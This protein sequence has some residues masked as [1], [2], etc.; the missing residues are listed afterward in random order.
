[1]F[2]RLLRTEGGFVDSPADH[3]GATKYGLSLRFLV[4]QA[5]ISPS[6]VKMLDI[7]RDGEIDLPDIRDMTT[8]EAEAVY[9]RFF[10]EPAAAKLPP[11]FDAAVFDQTVND[12]L[13]PA[14]KLLQRTL[15]VAADKGWPLPVT[16]YLGP[17]TAARLVEDISL[18]GS[19]R[20]LDGYRAAAAGR[21]RQIVD[22]DPAQA[23]F[24]DGWLTRA[25][26]LGDV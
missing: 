11:P 4:Q 5:K 2:A 26:E 16:G 25:A 6:L 12:G 17:Q 15:N 10:W 21:Y 20:L 13:V 8:V 7:N 1:V 14:V 22:A 23:G 9:R 18:L 24:L 3:G 19:E